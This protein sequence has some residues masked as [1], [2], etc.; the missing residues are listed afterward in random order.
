VTAIRYGGDL[1]DDDELHLC[2]V[3]AG[4]RVVE[5]G[6]ADESAAVAFARAGARAIAVDPSPERIDAARRQAAGVEVHVEL[7]ISALADLG[8]LTSGSVDL[9][10]SAGALDRAD[11]LARMFRQIHRVL[12][13]DGVL[14]M[15][16]KH[17]VAAMLEGDGVVLRRPYWST[18]AQTV[19]AL[20]M[21]LS[22]AGFVIDALLEPAPVSA[23]DALV[24]AGLVLRARK[25]GV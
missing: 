13:T 19:G 24:P 1:P 9:V 15:A 10:F 8:F 17:P 4:R 5:L 11:D 3:V 23:P 21:A 7:H 12:R 22:R 6:I 20:Y 18:A 2:G 25:L 16:T 14:V